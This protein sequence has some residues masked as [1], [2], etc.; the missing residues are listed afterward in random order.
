[1]PPLEAQT[2]M[3]GKWIT[4]RV[5]DVRSIPVALR[6]GPNSVVIIDP[7]EEESRF[8]EQELGKEIRFEG[9]KFDSSKVTPFKTLTA[10]DGP[11]VIDVSQEV[12]RNR[13]GGEYGTEVKRFIQTT[14][15]TK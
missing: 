11:F 12:R 6:D 15:S 3:D 5:F 2:Y 13:T 1:M 8:F 9:L 14:N 4:G 10:D 7:G